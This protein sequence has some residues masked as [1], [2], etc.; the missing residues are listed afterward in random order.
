M[1]LNLAG[2]KSYP[3]LRR[4][5]RRLLRRA[6]YK[7]Y[8]PGNG[9][10]SA[11][12]LTVQVHDDAGFKWYWADPDGRTRVS[13]NYE[14]SYKPSRLATLLSGALDVFYRTSIEDERR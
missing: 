7:I 10:S 6:G 12:V 8:N 13:G 9:G 2:E 3:Q 14:G 4:R 11:T 5:I 1:E